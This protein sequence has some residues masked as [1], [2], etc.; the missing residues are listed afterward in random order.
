MLGMANGRLFGRVVALLGVGVGTLSLAAET[1]T[2]TGAAT[3]KDCTNFLA[4]A[5]WNPARVP[6]GGDTL[7][8]DKAVALAPCEFDFGADGLT[9]QNSQQVQFRTTFK[10]SGKLVK[11][12]A[13]DLRN[14]Y[15]CRHTGGTLILDGEIY[16]NAR[17]ENNVNGA[18]AQYPLG[19]GQ[20]E[21]RR[22]PT[23]SPRL[24]LQNYCHIYSPILVSGSYTA[25]QRSFFENNNPN[26]YGPITAEDDFLAYCSWSNGTSTGAGFRGGISAHGH[27]AFISNSGD[28]ATTLA[29]EIDAS[30]TTSKGYVYIENGGGTDPDA[31]LSV[32]TGRC[33]IKETGYWKGRL[34]RLTAN[35]AILQLSNLNNLTTATELEVASG[36]KV[37]FASAVCVRVAKLTVAGV[38]KPAGV[39]TS[40]NAG[41]FISGNGALYVGTTEAPHD[42]QR[43]TWTNNAGDFKWSNAANWSPALVP[44]AGDTAVFTKDV[45]LDDKRPVEPVLM[46]EGTLTI[47][48]TSGRIFYSSVSINGPVAIVKTGS[49][50]WSA[51]KG[52]PYTG[53]TVVRAGRLDVRASHAFG[54]GTVTIEKNDGASPELR[55][56]SWDPTFT[57]KVV[58]LGN[59]SGYA[60]LSCSNKFNLKGLVESEYDFKTV[61]YY[62]ALSLEG[63]VSAS[64]RTVY[65]NHNNDYRDNDSYLA[66]SFD[67]SLVLQG[68]Y[69]R[70][71]AC[72]GVGVDHLLEIQDGTNTALQAGFSWEGTNVV[73]GGSR[74]LVVLNGNNNFSPEAELRVSNGAKLAFGTA[75]RLV[76][77]RLFDGA[78][79][80]ASGEYSSSELPNLFV[81][82]EGRVFVGRGVNEWTGGGVAGEWSDPDNWLAKRVPQGGEI[83]FIDS[84]VT[85]TNRAGA[86]V[87]DG[88]L[89]VDHSKDIE[90][91]VVLTGSGRLVKRG[92]G[93]FRLHT[94]KLQHEGGLRIENGIFQMDQKCALGSGPVTLVRTATVRPMFDLSK[95]GTSLVLTNDFYILGPK[96][97]NI[98]IN[99]NND[100]QFNGTITAED[101]IRIQNVWS[102]SKPNGT[103]INAT[104]NAPGHTVIFSNCG[105]VLNGSSNAS[106]R[107]ASANSW[108]F[109]LGPNFKGT[110]PKATLST[111]AK[112]F[113]RNGAEWAGRVEVESS[114]T[115]SVEAG[116]SFHAASLAINGV[117]QPVGYYRKNSAPSGAT[118]GSTF[119]GD[120]CF[121]VGQT[122]CCIIFR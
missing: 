120:G 52:S 109:T 90:W 119:V 9:I 116:A 105:F 74:T 67:A 23:T 54:T 83:A 77:K 47:E 122:G 98:D 50:V 21:I 96:G 107:F 113:F 97:S 22:S 19:T 56:S 85:I 101:D 68:R 62:G 41:G 7:V 31:V 15:V 71:V 5:N 12:G 114:G 103:T 20:I 10:G 102:N 38:E 18:T 1:L 64:D 53:G 24:N 63:G 17:Y 37:D 115:L 13:G 92:T 39:Y 36:A 70:S 55:G 58:I 29:G 78:N 82:N 84:A 75:S 42:A 100:D 11:T 66:G 87:I 94:T 32:G 25:D 91:H 30:L 104:F 28:Y 26:V 48:V 118:P 95:A 79:E 81:G 14:H 65:H 45:A 3:G 60:V 69:K 111:V 40:A 108:N 73:I 49:G 106:I 57:N 89:V 117:E 59:T 112:T 93:I 34:V 4:T 6:K 110:D 88:D 33:L 16:Q 61:E 86:V 72:T 80:I 2:W 121:V 35:D 8:F 27:T 99:G 51:C 76:V 46:G 44:T 43:I